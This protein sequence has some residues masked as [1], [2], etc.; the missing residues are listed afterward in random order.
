MSRRKKSDVLWL[1]FQ[2][3]IQDRESIIDAHV[4]IP[5]AREVKNAQRDIRA[6]RQMMIELFGTDKSQGDVIL[7]KMKPA[8]MAELF[9]MVERGELLCETD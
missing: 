1:A 9:A 6:F 3:A 4:S 5:N 2:Y 8:T 7:E